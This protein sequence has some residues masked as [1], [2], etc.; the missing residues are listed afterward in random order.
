MLGDKL[1]YPKHVAQN[2]LKK[3]DNMVRNKNQI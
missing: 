1:K 2:L 3:S